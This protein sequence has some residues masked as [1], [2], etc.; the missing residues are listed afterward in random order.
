MLCAQF[1]TVPLWIVAEQ[2]EC[3]VSN[4]FCLSS[5]VKLGPDVY[6]IVS[7]VCK[8]GFQV[9]CFCVS[10]VFSSIQLILLNTI[11]RLVPILM[12]LSV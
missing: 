10:I 6:N 4:M 12:F 7:L 11:V 5:L 3:T 2:T 1:V 8:P 9:R